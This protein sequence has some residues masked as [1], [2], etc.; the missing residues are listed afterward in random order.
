LKRTIAR[1]DPGNRF[2][3]AYLWG[4]AGI[5]INVAKTSRILPDAPLNSWRLIYD[6]AILAKLGSCGVSIV[7]APSEVIATALMSMG[8]DPNTSTEVDFEAA[9]VKL[10]AIRPYVRK[11]ESASQISDLAAGD[12]CLMLTW[13]TNVVQARRRADESGGHSDLRYVIP[14]EGTIGW[15]PYEPG[16]RRPVVSSREFGQDSGRGVRAFVRRDGLT[17]AG[18]PPSVTDVIGAGLIHDYTQFPENCRRLS[19]MKRNE[20]KG[21]ARTGSPRH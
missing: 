5:G 9:A 4:T 21:L 7:D 14:I 20:L 16:E 6:P 8:K 2:A 10:M 19:L 1:Q 12:I 3:A 13:T 17:G 15:K 18:R 11:I